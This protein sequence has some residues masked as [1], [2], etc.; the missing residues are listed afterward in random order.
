M[1]RIK[2]S[3]VLVL[4]VA[5]LGMS[6]VMA[7]CGNV[8]E[9][10]AEKA[11]EKNVGG[12]AEVDLD[13]DGNVEIT[14]DEGSFKTGN[15]EWPGQIPSD[16]PRFKE[17]KIVSVLENNTDEQGKGIL[18]GIENASLEAVANYKEE[19][20]KNGWTIT[21]TSNTPESV[22]FGAEKNNSVVTVS[23][24]IS[25]GKLASGG[26]TYSEKN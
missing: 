10:A 6:L 4:L 16:V 5:F 25:E 12:N 20:E 13:K 8:A 7:G 2:T 15:A 9:K 21:L 23:F 26:V 14:T 11:I 1:I 22:M 3:W 18:V 24:A 17:G 19:L